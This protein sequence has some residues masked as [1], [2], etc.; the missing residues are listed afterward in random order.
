MTMKLELNN[1][2]KKGIHAYACPI[3]IENGNIKRGEFK[4]G[5]PVDD[6]N[7]T[8]YQFRKSCL[9]E[10]HLTDG[11]YEIKEA[12]GHKTN[13]YYIL[14]ESSQ[15]VEQWRTKKD[16]LD[17]LVPV[18]SNLPDLEGTVRQVEWAKDIRAKA[19]RAN[20]VT[21]AI[22]FSQDQAKWWIDNRN[23]M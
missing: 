22:A 11:L 4:N 3:S 7:R 13:V 10:I 19:L 23:K 1:Y 2:A 6:Y 16:L 15:M 20:R 21:L 18:S 8:R 5:V 14:V 17:S 9:V 12:S